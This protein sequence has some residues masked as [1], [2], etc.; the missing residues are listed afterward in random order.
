MALA[1]VLLMAVALVASCGSQS[2]PAMTFETIG[3]R[4]EMAFVTLVSPSADEVS[5]ADLA[6][7][8]KQDWQWQLYRGYEIQV[9]VF[10]NK[11]APERWLEVWDASVVEFEEAMAQIYPHWIATYS[12]NAISAL[13]QVE[14]LSRDANADVVRTITFRIKDRP[15]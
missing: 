2:K 6:R 12:R 7:R 8:L 1:G 14:I 10:D 4:G 3:I 15:D 11:E 9:L 5:A 13:H